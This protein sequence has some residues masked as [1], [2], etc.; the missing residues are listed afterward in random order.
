MTEGTEIKEAVI[1]QLVAPPGIENL[2]SV[3]ITATK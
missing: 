2:L 3:N 1:E